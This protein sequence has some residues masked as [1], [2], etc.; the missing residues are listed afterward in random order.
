[1]SNPPQPTYPMMPLI[2][3]QRGAS[4]ERNQEGKKKLKKSGSSESF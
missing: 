1:M 4:R 2:P 3:N